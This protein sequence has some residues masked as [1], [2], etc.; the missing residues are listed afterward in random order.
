MLGAVILFGHKSERPKRKPRALEKESFSS[1]DLSP[2]LHLFL[3]LYSPLAG[4]H[5][6]GRT[7]ISK[8]P[9]LLHLYSYDQDAVSFFLFLSSFSGFSY[10]IKLASSDNFFLLKPASG[11]HFCYSSLYI[12]LYVWRYF[13]VF[14]HASYLQ[15][16]PIFCVP[17]WSFS[18][19]KTPASPIYTIDYSIGEPF[20]SSFFISH[21]PFSV[22]FTFYIFHQ[23]DYFFFVSLFLS[24][25]P[26]YTYG[27]N[28]RELL[29]YHVL[30]SEILSNVENASVMLVEFFIFVL[31]G[32]ETE[33]DWPLN[34]KLIIN[35]LDLLFRAYW[36]FLNRWFENLLRD[37]QFLWGEIRDGCKNV[38]KGF[39]FLW[40]WEQRPSEN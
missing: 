18:F 26:T 38:E 27:S 32:A 23:G 25:L 10:L 8:H 29:F 40:D 34:K 12:W 13:Y 11:N 37:L 16:L 4:A 28:K 14:V 1:L 39:H 35:N 15:S 2:S 36:Y 24:Q 21:S 17:I 33:K 3:V 9:I 6:H 22:P 7:Y 20:C 5:T 31:H 19:P 30:A